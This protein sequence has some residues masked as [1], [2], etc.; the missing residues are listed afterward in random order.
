MEN[1]QHDSKWTVIYPDLG[2]YYFVDREEALLARFFST[3]A[4]ACE[5]IR[6]KNG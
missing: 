3:G 5:L 6:P 1:I 2:E 4:I